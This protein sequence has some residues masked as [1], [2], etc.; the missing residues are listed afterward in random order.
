MWHARLGKTLK[1]ELDRR[2]E[3]K[4]DVV[5]IY[6]W[7]PHIWMPMERDKFLEY[8]RWCDYEHR[9]DTIIASGYYNF[10]HAEGKKDYDHTFIEGKSADCPT[11]THVAYNDE[12]YKC[13]MRYL[14]YKFPSPSRFE[15]NTSSSHRKVKEPDIR[16]VPVGEWG[17]DVNPF[18][19]SS[20][21]LTEVQ[22][23]LA[24]IRETPT[25]NSLLGETSR[26]EELRL[27]GVRGWRTVWRDII[28]RWREAT[29]DGAT[30]FSV[31]KPRSAEAAKIITAYMSDPESMRTI[32]FGSVAPKPAAQVSP[33]QALQAS[34]SDRMALHGRVLASL[35]GRAQ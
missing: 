15:A 8:A 24:R 14:Y 23:V 32:R 35:R 1:R 5:G 13:A 7:E 18:P 21:E 3:A 9:D 12:G 25:W 19:A 34:D 10:V 11:T 20:S 26:A 22:G 28:A 4:E 30:L 6:Y 27:F 2:S 16:P 29:Q 31:T 17:D 33:R